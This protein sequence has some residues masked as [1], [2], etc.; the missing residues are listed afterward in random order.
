MNFLDQ[1]FFARGKGIAVPALKAATTAEALV[2][3]GARRLIDGNLPEASRAS[4]VAHLNTI[5][6]AQERA[7]TAAYLLAGSPE[8]QLI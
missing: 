2:D 5:K 8:F 1:V 6:D 3:E 4:V 7:A